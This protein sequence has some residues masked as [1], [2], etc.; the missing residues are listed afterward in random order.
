LTV[1]WNA[2]PNASGYIIQYASNNGFNQNLKEITVSDGAA[3]SIDITGLPAGT[4]F[5]VRVVAVGTGGYSNSG[6]SGSIT[7]STLTAK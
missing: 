6:N 4:R 7:I 3:T 1:S 5:Y 2:V